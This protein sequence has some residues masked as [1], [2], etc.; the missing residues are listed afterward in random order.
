MNNTDSTPRIA[1]IGTGITGLTAAAQLAAAGK[2]CILV[3]S[4]EKVGGLCQTYE[5]DGIKFDLGP[6]LFFYNPHSA[7]DRY[8]LD[9][10]KDEKI[11]SNRFRFAIHAK[12]RYWRM[13]ADIMDIL[14]HYPLNYKWQII[15][16]M[17]GKGKGITA[18]RDSVRAMI[19]ERLGPDYYAD[20][21]GPF[22]HKKT[23]VSP[24]QL[25]RDWS[26]R[27]E[28]DVHNRKIVTSGYEKTITLRD[29]LRATFDPRYFYPLKGIEAIATGIWDRYKDA[30][31]E[32]ILQ[33]GPI[34]FEKDGA[35]ITRIIVKGQ[36][37]PV[38]H[39]VWTPSI[40][41][42]NRV[43]GV[44]EHAIQYIDLMIV[45]MTF[46]RNHAVRR[47]FAYTYHTDEQLIFN[48]LYYPDNL[49]QQQRL[50]NKEGLCVEINISPELKTASDREIVDRVLNGIESLGLYRK[51][52]LREF[53]V[54][55]L[56]E[57]MPVYELNYEAERERVFKA[58][59][60]HS[61]LYAIGRRGGYLFCLTPAAVRQGL[62]M[63]DELMNQGNG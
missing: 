32:T 8:I 18:N 39:V 20:V 47:P 17:I 54:V 52:D 51:K 6:H 33:C 7:A 22:T 13:P 24:D 25:H 3:E 49:Y 10:L 55:R 35:R 2:K 16:A 45:M 59:H 50:A 60:D 36:P 12:G 11:V 42:L 31:G 27:V 21:F 53:R 62:Q 43:L 57:A 14:L 23:L 40:N 1:I 56:E 48:R 61:N 34:T 63:A 37:I 46:N 28:R 19:E 30:G 4:A 9:V 58:V 15:R 44:S 41:A 5:M 29:K 38:T 26:I